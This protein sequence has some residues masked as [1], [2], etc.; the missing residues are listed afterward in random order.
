MEIV[1]ITLMVE[2]PV[3]ALFSEM[4]SKGKFRESRIEQVLA[5]I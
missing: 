1:E 3:A 2:V 4:F 5:F